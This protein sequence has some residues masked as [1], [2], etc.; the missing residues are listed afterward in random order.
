MSSINHRRRIRPWQPKRC[1]A[2][3]KNL[4]KIGKKGVRVARSPFCNAW[5]MPNGRCRVHGGASTGPRTPEGKARVVAAMLEGRRKWVERRRA[6]GRRFTAGRKGGDAWVTEG[7]RKLA[8]AEAHRL[9]GRRFT[10]DRP[11]ALALLKSA[12]GDPAATAKAK[13]VLGAQERVGVDRDR[14]Q[15]LAIVNSLR[16]AVTVRQS[17]VLQSVGPNAYGAGVE[18]PADPAAKFWGRNVPK[19]LDVLGKILSQE[20][21]QCRTTRDMRKMRVVNAAATTV[22]KAAIATDKNVLSSP[23][24]I[25]VRLEVS[26]KFLMIPKWRAVSDGGPENIS[27]VPAPQSKPELSSVSDARAGEPLRVEG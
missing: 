23:R 9:G 3:I 4:V 12:K 24:R 15:A 22:I 1:D 7:M 8:R 19:A 25:S 18:A 26:T 21:S 5:A 20:V 10:L 17:E 13:A 11:L 6:E 16:V 27:P 2:R 14:E